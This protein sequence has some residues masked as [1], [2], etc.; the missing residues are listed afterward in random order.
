V[1]R[2][3]QI[4]NAFNGGEIAPEFHGRTDTKK[5]GTGAKRIENMIVHPE[6]GAHRRPGTRFVKGVID[7]AKK[8]RLIPFIYSTTQAYILEFSEFLIRVFANELNVTVE[9]HADLTSASFTTDEFTYTDHGYIDQ[10]G[11]FRLTTTG[12][13]DTGLSLATD[14]YISSPPTLTFT[15]TEVRLNTDSPA[16][17]ILFS[18]GHGL[19]AN[20]GP[21]L[22]STTGY[23]PLGYTEGGGIEYFI[24]ITSA[25]EIQVSRTAGGVAVVFT[26]PKIGGGTHTL[27][28]AGNYKRDAFRL[29]LTAGGSA[30]DI[31]GTGTGTHTITPN[32][33]GTPASLP[34]EIPTPYTEADLYELRY[35]QSADFLFITNKNHRPAQLTRVGTTKWSLDF[36]S[37]TDGPF[38]TENIDAG[39]TLDPSGI[40]SGSNTLL[41][42]AGDDGWVA[43]R[44]IGRLVRFRQAGLV[45]FMEVVGVSTA[46]NANVHILST[47]GG[48]VAEDQF[49]YGMWS[50][51]NW[52]SAI[53][54]FEQR[55]AISG[56]VNS[57]QTLHGSQTSAY[58]SFGAT[59]LNNTVV[60]TNAVNFAIGMNE[61]NSISWMAAG[62]RLIIGTSSGLFTARGSF[63]GE[64][65]T[66][67]NIQVQRIT[68][69][70]ALNLQPVNVN[71]QIVYVTANSQSLRGFALSRDSDTVTP[72]DLS[73][74]S[75]HVFG[76]TLSVT[77]MAYQQDR[78][79]VI[80]C[81]RSDGVLAACTYVPEQEVFAWHRHTLGGSFS[82]GGAVVE[83]VAVIP[84]PGTT[85]DQ[86]WMTV[87]RTVNS[88]T[89]RHIEF[90]EDEWVDGVQTSMRYM[91]SAPAAYSDTPTNTFTGF[92]HLEGETVQVLADGAVHPDRVVTSGSI[93]LDANYGDVVAGLQYTSELETL[94]LDVPDPEG[95]SVGKTG[96]IDHVNLRVYET[97]G[98]EIGPDT[99]NLDPIQWGEVPP[100]MDDPPAIFTGDKMIAFRGPFARQKII[101]VR[102]DQP[103]P[104]NLLSIN[105]IQST[106][107]R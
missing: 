39:I 46:A 83:S 75:K 29:S 1:P 20:M 11:P 53:S 60:D 30:V 47:L 100:T 58:N 50:N 95:S 88:L 2:I 7:D 89:V 17:T 102:Q 66:P 79:S 10:Q 34:L 71:D 81:V 98:G 13:L 90:F 63:D 94:S 62:N 54:F 31:T 51:A 92:D 37:I 44:D 69:I 28:P 24:L 93:T 14:Y 8:S 4:I 103:L 6:G 36:M 72:T 16:N 59:Q 77:D 5:Y 101:V 61:V 19:S 65:I 40:T 33:L 18:G 12:T 91:D 55:L 96:R 74:L 76:R 104:F 97:I 105:V 87:K 45:G 68:A 26:G 27:A 35:V 9:E 78:Q 67:S 42:R 70:G 56:E 57:P 73:L 82:S 99:S 64:P 43:E 38:G 84:S 85:H 25:T 106:G 21:Y 22:F 52:P 3:S 23:L 86:V 49:S 107:Q 48:S 41:Q 15:D 32:P 80:W